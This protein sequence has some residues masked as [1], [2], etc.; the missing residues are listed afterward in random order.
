M[1]CVVLVTLPCGWFVGAEFPTTRQLSQHEDPVAINNNHPSRWRRHFHHECHG[2]RVQ[3]LP[4]RPS[5]FPFPH[6]PIEYSQRDHLAAVCRTAPPPPSVVKG[7]SAAAVP[8][9][10]LSSMGHTGTTRT[11]AKAPGSTPRDHASKAGRA[12]LEGV[13]VSWRLEFCYQSGGPAGKCSPP[14]C[15]LWVNRYCSSHH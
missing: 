6:Y 4:P 3:A 14:P 15:S 8:I 9:Y 5:P 7:L 13:G 11:A 2:L 12:S 1:G 10:Q